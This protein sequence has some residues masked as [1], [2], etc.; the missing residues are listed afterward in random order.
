MFWVQSNLDFFVVLAH[1]F[2]D[3]AMDPYSEGQTEYC[4]N[5]FVKKLVSTIDVAAR[6]VF[7]LRL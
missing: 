3:D 1:I 2:F 6:S 5:Q 4:V 7:E